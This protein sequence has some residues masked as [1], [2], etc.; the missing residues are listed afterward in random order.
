MVQLKRKEILKI[1]IGVEEVIEM[2]LLR[3]I[4]GGAKALFTFLS[5]DDGRARGI[6][7][8]RHGG[9]PSTNP[10][11]WASHPLFHGRIWHLIPTRVTHPET[12]PV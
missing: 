4:N 5:D 12:I 8:K 11:E 1:E 7:S 2:F 3:K 6:R 10:V 9:Q